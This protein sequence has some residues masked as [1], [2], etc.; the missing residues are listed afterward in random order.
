[1]KHN[2]Y[3]NVLLIAALS[4]LGS[5]N[6]SA[7]TE[8]KNATNE[9]AECEHTEHEN[10]TNEHTEG[11]HAEGEHAEDEHA[12]HEHA[13]HGHEKAELIKT[14]NGG[15]LIQILDSYVEFWVTSDRFVQIT[16]MDTSGQIVPATDQEVALI[17]G[18][19]AAPTVL[20]FVKKGYVLL[21]NAPLPEMKSMPIILQLK[22][23]V[24][25][26]RKT[27]RERFHLNMNNCPSCEYLEYACICVH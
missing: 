7:S 15:R 5:V 4:L 20:E 8:Q 13:T 27:I 11:E 21:S 22:I 23:S 17:G 19:R 9:H 10:A 16:F 18:D 25:S 2:I 12:E 6:V 24:E 3:F 14:P 1:M 26:E